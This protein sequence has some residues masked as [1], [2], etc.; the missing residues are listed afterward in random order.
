MP[1]TF[2]A[3]YDHGLFTCSTCFKVFSTHFNKLI[4][5][6]KYSLAVDTRKV[7]K[8]GRIDRPGVEAG[9]R[10]LKTCTAREQNMIVWRHKC[11]QFR[12][13]TANVSLVK[14]DRF[15]SKPSTFEK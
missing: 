14:R 6:R 15:E 1:V 5:L 9:E 11:C 2:V 7:N 4:L 3:P 13:E 12:L 10:N 8:F